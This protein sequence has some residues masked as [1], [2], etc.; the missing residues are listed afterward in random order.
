MSATVLKVEEDVL[1]GMRET[2]LRV[3]L[4]AQD[5][6]QWGARYTHELIKHEVAVRGYDPFGTG[7]EYPAKQTGP[8]RFLKEY[9]F[10]HRMSVADNA[11]ASPDDVRHT[12][13]V[14]YN[15]EAVDAAEVEAVVAK[16]RKH[17]VCAKVSRPD[18]NGVVEIDVIGQ[19][20][21]VSRALEMDIEDLLEPWDFPWMQ[22]EEL[23]KSVASRINA[24][25]GR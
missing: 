4:L 21:R 8:F 14:T 5:D 24:V 3:T 20:Y 25:A 10:H 16:C 12:S 22:D 17:G 6:N 19:L 7:V 2:H 1:P 11:Y 9:V 15:I 23:L 13:I 18:A